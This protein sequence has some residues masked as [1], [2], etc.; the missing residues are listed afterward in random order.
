MNDSGRIG[1]LLLGGKADIGSDVCSWGA[2]RT[3]DGGRFR[4]ICAPSASRG[5]V[6]ERAAHLLPPSLVFLAGEE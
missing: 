1:C 4:F 6:G 3:S 2:K 5:Q